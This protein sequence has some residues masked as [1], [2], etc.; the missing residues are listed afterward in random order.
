MEL[1]RQLTDKELRDDEYV[2]E[3]PDAGLVMRWSLEVYTA[4]VVT[5]LHV[6]AWPSRHHERWDPVLRGVVINTS[7][8]N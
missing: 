1:V 6:E 5:A 7:S 4:Q 3:L 2:V 8:N